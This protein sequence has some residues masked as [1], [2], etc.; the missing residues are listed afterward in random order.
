MKHIQ[1]HIQGFLAILVLAASSTFA[2]A[3]S[4]SLLGTDNRGNITGSAG[5][6]VGYGFTFTN[7]T[8]QFALLDSSQL[9]IDP[10]FAAYTDFIGINSIE[11][12]PYQTFSEDFS[13][14]LSPNP[15]DTVQNGLA[16]F[17]IDSNA[18]IG[19]MY[20]GEVTLTYDLF[21]TDP[22]VD[23]NAVGTFGN[24]LTTS[25]GLEVVQQQGTPPP[26][27]SAVPEPSSLVLIGTAAL[28]GAAL[29]MHRQKQSRCRRSVRS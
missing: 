29:L 18:Q 8:D 23:P 15:G 10:S 9:D 3:D 22:N 12:A 16:Q 4:F 19:Q 11:V 6:L 21:T 5:Q 13:V 26:P 27:V 24:T 25:I 1:I 14:V 17:L 2:S 20:H 28:A 7:A